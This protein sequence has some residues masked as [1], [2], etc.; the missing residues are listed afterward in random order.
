M[1]ALFYTNHR[2]KDVTTF[3]GQWRQL[4]ADI[5]KKEEE[6]ARQRQIQHSIES[7]PDMQHAGEHATEEFMSESIL[8]NPNARFSIDPDEKGM[9]WAI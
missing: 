9:Q 3:F 4:A 7:P 6:R 8:K 2:M 1:A 5:W